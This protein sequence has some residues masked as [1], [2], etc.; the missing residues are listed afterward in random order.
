MCVSL[1]ARI[2]EVTADRRTAVAETGGRTVALSL[3]LLVLE[4]AEVE[5]G[6]W[7]LASAGSA[8]AALTEDEARDLQRPFGEEMA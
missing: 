3:D 2:V 4:G 1:P 6:D 8:L 7:V 5:P